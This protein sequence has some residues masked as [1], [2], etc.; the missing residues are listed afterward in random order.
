VA[1]SAAV[2]ACG[3]VR[4]GELVHAAEQVQ[5]ELIETLGPEACAAIPGGATIA[6]DAGEVQRV[7]DGIEAAF[8][9]AE[10]LRSLGEHLPAGELRVTAEQAGEGAAADLAGGIL[11]LARLRLAARVLEA[12]AGWAAL[13]QGLRVSESVGAWGDVTV[14]EILLAFR[15]VDPRLIE[16]VLR[17]ALLAPFTTFEECSAEALGRLAQVLDAHAA[18]RG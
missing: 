14:S 18:G 3:L 4:I 13:A 5:L 6:L 7:R 10:E 12:R 17:D 9:L 16:V 1:P 2:Q 15:D 8:E 11:D